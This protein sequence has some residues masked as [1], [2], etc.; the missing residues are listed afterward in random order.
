MASDK[1][2]SEEPFSLFLLSL[3]TG[4]KRRLTSP[5]ASVIGDCSPAFAPDGKLLAFVRVIS[6]VVGEVYLVSAD[7]GE[8]KRLTFDGA[9]ASN[10]AWT[11]NGREIVFSSRHG[12]RS[13]LFRIPVG[14][15]APQWLAAT[16][17]EAQYPAFSREGNRLAWRQSADN[18]DIFRLKRFSTKGLQTDVGG[19]ERRDLFRR[20]RVPHTGDHQ[21]LQL[22]EQKCEDGR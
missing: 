4:E 14:G 11:P 22:P 17:G 3:E 9:G 10:L 21:I 8:P 15:G 6:A 2:S 12:G 7:G 13:R 5:P 1:A 16:G 18:A 19:R 20:R